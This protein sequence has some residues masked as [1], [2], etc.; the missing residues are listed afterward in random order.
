MRL[1]LCFSAALMSLYA[2]GSGSSAPPIPSMDHGLPDH[3]FQVTRTS[4]GHLTKIEDGIISLD[5]EKIKEPRT[6]RRQGKIRVTADKKSELGGQKKLT[7]EDLKPGMY[8]KITYRAEVNTILEIRV[9]KP[10]SA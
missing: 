9:L 7:V 10:K 5:D 8:V 4:T 2:Q 1:A 6:L 3:P